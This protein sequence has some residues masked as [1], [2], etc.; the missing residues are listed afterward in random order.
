LF[1]LSSNLSL[2]IL[3]AEADLELGLDATLCILG[4]DAS[5]LYLEAVVVPARRKRGSEFVCRGR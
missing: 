3:D 5:D 2:C 1:P 4:G